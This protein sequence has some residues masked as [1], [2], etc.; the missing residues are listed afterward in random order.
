MSRFVINSGI[1]IYHASTCLAHK[2]VHQLRRRYIHD[3]DAHRVKY[4]G[5]IVRNYFSTGIDFTNRGKNIATRSTHVACLIGRCIS[6]LNDD[7]IGHRC[8]IKLSSI[9]CVPPDRCDKRTRFTQC[10]I[11]KWLFSSRSQPAIATH[12]KNRNRREL[13]PLALALRSHAIQHYFLL[14]S[15]CELS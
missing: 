12:S 4:N 14:N 9:S 3:G 15:S 11:K 6:R 10:A 8:I 7:G 13:T 5:G 2:F 1:G